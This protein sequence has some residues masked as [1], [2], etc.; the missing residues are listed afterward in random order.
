MNRLTSVENLLSAATLTGDEREAMKSTLERMG[1]TRL[2]V[3]RNGGL[4]S[5]THY[6]DGWVLTC[7]GARF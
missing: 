3:E 5:V 7:R 1:V 6:Q 4:Q 2:T